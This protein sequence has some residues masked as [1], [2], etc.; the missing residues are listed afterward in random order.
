[1]RSFLTIFLAAAILFSLTAGATIINIPDD[2]PTIQEGIDHGSDGDT[3]LVQP[4]TYYENV[5]FNGHNVV[6]ASL[7]LTTGDTA[8]VSS[9]LIDGQSAG[10]VITIESSED[11]RAQVVGFTIQNGLAE[12]GGGIRCSGTS[13]AIRNNNITDNS[14]VGQLTSGGGVGCYNSDV[15]I[16]GNRINGNCVES[17]DG[18]GSGGAIESY[19]STAEIAGNTISGNYVVSY[20]GINYGGGICC[21]YSN[22]VLTN[23]TI[24]GNSS[25]NAGW[26]GHG[27]GVYALQCDLVIQNNIF[28]ENSTDGGG[29]IAFDSSLSKVMN[30]TFW[31]NWGFCCGGG[32]CCEHSNLTVS[33][34]VFWQDSTSY[35]GPEIYAETG[36]LSVTYCDVQGGWPGEGNIDVGPLLR[37][38]ANRDFH[39]MADYCGDPFNSPCIDAGHPDSLDILLDCLHGL[40]TDRSDMGAYGGRNSGWPTAVEDDGNDLSIPRQFVLHQNYP[41]PFNATT[42]VTYQLPLSCDVKLEIYNVLGQRVATLQTA[43]RIQ[44]S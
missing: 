39:L 12:N 11:R 37:D 41:N 8:Y 13:P 22:A 30:N 29:G 28:A 23:N 19:R 10:S 36:T 16:S 43:G 31:G 6:L 9:T 27:G 17:W 33:N 18:I 21:S 7:F 32:I 2:Y 44:V 34:S 26:G 35:V 15:V 20:C 40:S 14:V 38:P 24:I 42:R 25:W 4:D 5:N 3:V 1:M